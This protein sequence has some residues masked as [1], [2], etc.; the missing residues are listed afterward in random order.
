MAYS[1]YDGRHQPPHRH[2]DP[3]VSRDTDRHAAARNTGFSSSINS[4]GSPSTYSYSYS[5]PR[6]AANP[7]LPTR[8]SAHPYRPSA[9]VRSKPRWP[10]SPSVEDEALSLAREWSSEA[11]RAPVPS[12]EA[13]AQARGSVDQYPIIEE[14]E[15]PPDQYDNR[16]NG[17]GSDSENDERRFVLVSDP[18]A[19]PRRKSFAERGNMAHLK[20]D[21]SDNDP[22]VF[23]ERTSTPYAYTKPQKERIAPSAEYFLSPESIT[24]SATS[25]TPRSV[26]S[27]D[28]WDAQRD[29]NARPP[30]TTVHSRYDSLTQSPRTPKT[31]TFEDDEVDEDPTRLR[32]ERKPA[33]Y[34]FV[35]SDLQK[36]DLRTSLLDSQA[37]SDKRRSE[38]A[39][40]QSPSSARGTY[41]SSSG[42][43]KNPTPAT[44]SPRSSNSSLNNIN[45]TH[46]RQKSRP[47]PVEENYKSSTKYSDSQPASPRPSSPLYREPLQSNPRSIPVESSYRSSSK[48]PD[49][50]P[51]SPRP[52]SPSY[53]DPPQSAPRSPKLPPRRPTDS[54]PSSRPSS[55]SGGIP[56]PISPLSTTLPSP[57]NHMSS[58]SGA[59]WHATY[60][61]TTKDRSRPPSRYNNR[62][63]SLPIPTPR[64]GVQSPSPIRAPKP[65]NPLP[66]PVDER[67]VDVFMPP[68]E[69][70]QF[71]HSY[72]SVPPPQPTSRQ[73]YPD[74]PNISSSPIPGSPRDRPSAFRP[75]AN[76]RHTATPDDSPRLAR[77]RSNSIRSQSSHEG[78][79]ERRTAPTSPDR[80]L[81]SCPRSEPTDK[82]DDWYTLEN[83]PN[84][85]ICPSC[86]DGV[87]SDTPFSVYFKQTRRFERPVERFCDFSSPWMRLAWLLTI[88]QRRSSPDLIYALATISEIERPCPKDREVSATWF[89]I[90]DQRDGVHISNFAVCPCDFKMIEALFPSIRGYFTRLPAHP[91]N[92]AP[93]QN[94]CSLRVTSRRFPKYLDLLVELDAE[95]QNS[96]RGPDISQFIQLAREYAYKGECC[97]DKKLSRKPWHYIPTLPE[98]AV[99]EECYD[100]LIWP[101]IT[102][103]NP[104][105]LLFN[106]TIQLVPGEDSDG[107]S[108]C[109]YSPRMRR[110]WSRSLE[111]EDIGYLK[112]KAIERKRMETR[113]GRERKELLLWSARL[114]RG[115]G[116]WE[117]AKQDLRE[118][119]QEWRGW[120]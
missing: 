31:D 58:I 36:E 118:V 22:P 8:S 3:Y 54:P 43:S 48:Y 108:C 62:H 33:R 95:A 37:K 30:K 79:R 61:P 99:C 28:T 50:R 91:H 107:T 59:D 110:V 63:E 104:V 105:A 80:P 44:Q 24:S 19:T 7:P 87:F 52:K 64:I 65:E 97:R 102:D 38:Q 13:Q 93:R 15:Q 12:G 98:F 46:S 29:Q 9:H 6:Y 14:I 67:P 101:A 119:D 74:L 73:S 83:C 10:P 42:S 1:D 94:V 20:T 49:S 2:H 57:H 17:S 103:G 51:V 76:I 18:A 116:E 40:R 21:I 32:T 100:D 92:G 60:P 66:Y 69:A 56:R 4:R 34:S 23:T 77:V 89:G 53:R 117:R 11:G 84:F 109:L 41:D 85:D 111:D 72:S 75:S 114:E 47:N 78:R 86:Y 90:P 120:E 45:G 70:Y 35:K 16:Y 113:L 39:P 112:R 82:Y 68:E 27:H 25:S 115:G 96:G 26:P 88:K 55:R 71:D 106:R 81:P 5:D